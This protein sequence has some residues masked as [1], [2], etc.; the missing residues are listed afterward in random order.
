[1]IKLDEEKYFEKV[2][3]FLSKDLKEE[4]KKNLK[5]S[6]KI[7]NFVIKESHW[8]DTL[9]TIIFWLTLKLYISWWHLLIC[10]KYI[11]EYYY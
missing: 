6:R 7:V 11:N 10:I 9:Y 4:F 3:I 1:M 2:L 5:K 8:R